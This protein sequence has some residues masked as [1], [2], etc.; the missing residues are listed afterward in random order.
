MRSLSILFLTL[1]S[2]AALAQSP[3]EP[4][5]VRFRVRY[6]T[7][8]AVYLEGGRNAGL[9]EGMK[10]VVKVSP[11]SAAPASASSDVPDD[12]APIVARLK[13]ASVA[14]TSAVCEIESATRQ[15]VAGD[16]ATLPRDE[17]EALVTRR[18]LSNTR[19]YPAV[20]SFSEGDPLDE[21]AREE[22]PR[23]PLP[24]I[25]QA[26][27]RVG[28][29][30]STLHNA[31][32]ASSSSF[33]M[34]LRADVTRINGTYWNLRGYWRGRLDSRTSNSQAT[35]QELIDRTYHL[36]LTYDNPG[37]SWVM[38]FGRLYLP[39]ASSLDTIDGGYFGRRLSPRATAGIFAGISLDP[40]VSGYDFNRR[41]A[42][43]FV[44]FDGGS[45]EKTHYTSTFGL[46]IVT[47]GWKIDRPFAFGENSLTFQN[48]VSLFHS[49]QLD[50]PRTAAGQ[51][52]AGAGLSRS[53]FTLRV[54]AH[55][56][57][58]FD[59][60]HNYFRDVPRFDPQLVGTGLLDKVLFQGFNVGARVELPHHVSVYGAV[61]HSNNSNDARPSWNNMLGVS[62]AQIWKTGLRADFRYSR[63]DSSFA[64]GSYRTFSLSRTFG[65]N[66][67]GEVQVGT[68]SFV[69]PFSV[70][71][72]ARFLNARADVNLGARYFLEGGFTLSRGVVQ[73][74][75]QWHA[76]IG[77]R[78]DNR[79]HDGRKEVRDAAKP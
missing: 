58:T 55:P 34:V 6:V 9:S 71:N 77:Y 29:D 5:R 23:P 59:F 46:G 40:A 51:P 13:V 4:M 37:S 65:E 42:G 15:L 76:M 28:F 14:A 61:G 52:P 17:V 45:Y 30:Y 57:V 53:F 48:R 62:V 24:E 70:D 27:G 8:D 26:R 11:S 72:G 22:V 60:S 36:A 41:I 75:T 73:D 35:L 20:V 18:T 66:L 79:K 3:E 67:T 33:G 69:S 10:L 19:Q 31:S 47:D 78:F 63:F 43:S 21:E 74:Y 39:W 68:Q 50:S 49:F 64:Q 38:G 12:E 1:L 2:T 56:R 16:F 7:G 54:Q 32:G 25:N 44:S